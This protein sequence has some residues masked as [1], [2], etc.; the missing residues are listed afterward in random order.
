LKSPLR[1][2]HSGRT[3]EHAVTGAESEI[4]RDCRTQIVGLAASAQVRA[5]SIDALD[6]VALTG[7]AGN[8]RLKLGVLRVKPKIESNL[9]TS[10]Y[11]TA[12]RVD[13]AYSRAIDSRLDDGRRQLGCDL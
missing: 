7:Q 2:I 6:V 13:A 1:R 9:S 3:H 4:P 12:L 11:H 8:R 5:E 10:K